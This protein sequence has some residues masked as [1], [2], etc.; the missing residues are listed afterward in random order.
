MSNFLKNKYARLIIAGGVV[1]LGVIFMVL[2]APK[3]APSGQSPN[4][5]RNAPEAISNANANTTAN[6]N[7]A[8]NTNKPKT[9]VKK[10][11]G[12]TEKKTPHFVSANVV[13]NATLTQMPGTITITFNAPLTTSTQSFVS[14]KKDDITSVTR[15]QSNI[16]S[17]RKTI[18]V[19]LNQTV[20]SGDYYVYYVACFA[21]T[22]CKDGAFGFH[23]KLP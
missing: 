16:N 10:P 3:P 4:A 7:T 18:S 23:L 12:F 22:G 19:N 2:T 1:I 20:E 21:D 11:A 9:V 14:V 17:E 8:T 6:T 13:N 5:N 15:T